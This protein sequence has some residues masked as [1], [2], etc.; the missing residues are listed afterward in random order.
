MRI[1]VALALA[2]P[3]LTGCARSTRHLPAVKEFSVE[4]YEGTWYEIARFPHDFEENLQSVTAEYTVLEDGGIQVV[5][6]GYD[7][8]EGEWKT[9]TGYAEPA[10]DPTVGQLDV[11][12]FWPFYGTYKIL[13]LDKQGYSY[14]LVTGD[15]Y[16]YLWILARDPD[17]PEDVLKELY[18]KAAEYG[19]DISRLETIRHWEY[20]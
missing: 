20:Q 5:N 9:V 8:A 4:K 13:E 6:R 12:F 2:L 7:T 11:T 1:L 16:E 18:Q 19:F 3:L 10:G 17:L 14:A 15:T